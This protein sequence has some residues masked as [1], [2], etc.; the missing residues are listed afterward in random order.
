LLLNLVRRLSPEERLQRALALSA[1][2]RRAGESGI[3]QAHP[4]ASEQEILTLIAQ[5]QLGDK[6]C[7]EVYHFGPAKRNP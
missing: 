5:R 7:Q 3:R 1:A 2:A 6:L 4:E